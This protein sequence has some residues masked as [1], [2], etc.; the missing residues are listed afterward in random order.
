MDPQLLQLTNR[1]L[2]LHRENLSEACLSWVFQT[3]CRKK[4]NKQNKKKRVDPN[5]SLKWGEICETPTGTYWI[6][7]VYDWKWI[8]LD[9]PR[10]YTRH[11]VAYCKTC[12]SN[13]F[14]E[15]HSG[16]VVREL[17]QYLNRFSQGRRAGDDRFA[18]LFHATK[19]LRHKEEPR[20][21]Y[22]KLWRRIT[23]VYAA[24][25]SSAMNY[26]WL[27]KLQWGYALQH[28]LG[29]FNAALLLSAQ[30]KPSPMSSNENWKCVFLG[31]WATLLGSLG[32]H[33]N[34]VS[35]LLEDSKV[36]IVRI[37]L[38]CKQGSIFICYMLYWEIKHLITG[39]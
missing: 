20:Y 18:L 37:G 36:V 34:M 1:S 35:V 10:F 27:S 26:W 5:R 17:R 12:K 32:N 24:S 23:H 38:S 19:E 25:L 9:C 8:L 7:L 33:S 2:K 28:I 29:T 21:C 6:T 31:L 16:K 11:R 4:K 3:H 13:E 22:S 14:L 39:R 15:A 30:S